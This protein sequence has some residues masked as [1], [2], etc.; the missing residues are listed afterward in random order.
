MAVTA[1]VRGV[2][3]ITDNLTGSTSLTKVLNNSYT[4][5]VESYGQQVL[6]GTS[7]TSISLPLSPAQFVYVKNLSSTTSNT[8]TVTWTLTGGSSNQVVVLDPSAVLILSELTT[9][10]GIT[11]LSLVASTAATP[12]EYIL[13]G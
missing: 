2:I 7:P 5:T 10:N 1:A 3:T 4:G 8:L 12:V 6:I 9:A 13:C 11:A